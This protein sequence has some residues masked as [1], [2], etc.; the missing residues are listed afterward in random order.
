NDE[1]KEELAMEKVYYSPDPVVV[2][3]LTDYLR[4]RSLVQEIEEKSAL[5]SVLKNAMQLIENGIEVGE[6]DIQAMLEGATSLS[7]N[8]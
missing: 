3:G 2:G 7:V 6:S 4:G 1:Y 5:D 8:E